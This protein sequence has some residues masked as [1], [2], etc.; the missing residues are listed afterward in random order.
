MTDYK[1]IA[2]VVAKLCTDP[3]VTSYKPGLNKKGG[4]RRTGPNCRQDTSSISK[5]SNIRIYGRFTYA[6]TYNL[7]NILVSHIDPLIFEDLRIIVGNVPPMCL[8]N[9]NR[10]TM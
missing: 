4:K 6:G 9:G 7:N 10:L 2:T 8:P 3:K 1:K 5:I